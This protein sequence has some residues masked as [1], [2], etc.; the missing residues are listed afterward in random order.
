MAISLRVQAQEKQPAGAVPKRSQMHQDR[1]DGKQGCVPEIFW[2][3]HGPSSDKNIAGRNASQGSGQDVSSEQSAPS[4]PETRAAGAR[5]NIPDPALAQPGQGTKGDKTCEA[6]DKPAAQPQSIHRALLL[7]SL[8]VTM[9]LVMLCQ[10]FP[11]SSR[12]LAASSPRPHCSLLLCWLL[13]FPGS[14]RQVLLWA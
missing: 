5:K 7:P 1:I 11:V 14:C 2:K 12:Q 4:R 6:A 9:H 8:A 13:P 3:S 10:Q